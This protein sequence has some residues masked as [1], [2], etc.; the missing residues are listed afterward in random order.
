MTNK[1]PGFN[2]ESAIYR[3][4]NHYHISG[5]YDTLTEHE[6]ILPQAL[7]LGYSCDDEVQTCTCIGAFDCLRLGESGKCKGRKTECGATYCAC[8]KERV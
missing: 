4:T 5:T 1:L 2:A 8:S 6:K 7:S 3:T